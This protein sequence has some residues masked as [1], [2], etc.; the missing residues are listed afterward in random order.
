[1]IDRESQSGCAE[2][3]EG[4]EAG[5]AG[6]GRAEDIKEVRQ[7]LNTLPGQIRRSRLPT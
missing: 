1:M 4:T 6:Q 5:A 3:K 2:E 7:D